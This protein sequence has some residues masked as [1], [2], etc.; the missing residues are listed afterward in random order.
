MNL[1]MMCHGTPKEF[2]SFSLKAEQTVQYRGVFGT[3]LKVNVALKLAQDLTGNPL[4]DDKKLA[5]GLENYKPTEP[6]VGANTFAPD[7]KLAGD[8]NLPCF[9]KNMAN[10]VWIHLDSSFRMTLGEM[11]TS[12]LLADQPFLLN[13][14]CCTL[15]PG[16][17]ILPALV[18]K[19]AMVKDLKMV[20]QPSKQKAMQT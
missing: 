9:L 19:E 13:L 12:P 11:V 17:D 5:M 7:L 20:L 3:L 1:L 14:L 2:S 6:C 10:G 18:K 15:I 4:M 16:A 8:D